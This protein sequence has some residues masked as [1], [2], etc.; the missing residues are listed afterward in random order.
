MTFTIKQHDGKYS[1]KTEKLQ[2]DM[3][4][5]TDPSGNETA[6]PASVM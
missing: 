6:V 3:Q 1:W 4:L 2:V 5:C